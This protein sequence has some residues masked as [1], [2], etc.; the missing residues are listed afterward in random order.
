M[1]PFMESEV[2]FILETVLLFGDE[3]GSQF[4]LFGTGQASLVEKE[5]EP[6]AEWKA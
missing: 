6:A 5:L 1:D 2:L 4:T 3:F